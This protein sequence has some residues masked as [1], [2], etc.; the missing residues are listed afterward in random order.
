MFSKHNR[1]EFC[2]HAMLVEIGM[3][4]VIQNFKV[5]RCVIPTVSIT[6]YKLQVMFLLRC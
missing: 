5:E 6:R 1:Y 2:E 4:R 3:S